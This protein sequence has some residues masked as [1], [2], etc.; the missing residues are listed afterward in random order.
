MPADK[1][2]DTDRLST[3][4]D[5]VFAVIVTIMVLQL[6][7]PKS[8]HLSALITMWQPAV[9]Y[10][11]S[12]VFI[13]IVWINHHYI[14]RLV[15]ESSLPIIWIN[16]VHLFFVSL[17]PFTTAWIA[18]T[19]LAAAPVAVYTALFVCADATYNVFERRVLR[20]CGE[21]SEQQRRIARYRSTM[22]FAL[23]TSA[24]VLAA[25]VPWAG[26][27]LTCLALVLHLKPDVGVRGTADR[28]YP[29]PIEREA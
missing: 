26:F 12:Y 1:S 7:A 22:A 23:F 29:A 15:H 2:R 17:V 3:Y 28:T 10:L 25:F 11:V 18:Q 8:P 16:F 20:D 6:H 21:L 9:A 5:G 13:A 14:S 24:A 4:S 27:G 19:R